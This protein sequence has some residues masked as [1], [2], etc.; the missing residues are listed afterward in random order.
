MEKLNFFKIDNIVCCSIKQE[1]DNRIY[2]SFSSRACRTINIFT[3]CLAYFGGDPTWDHFAQDPVLEY[4]RK[5][6]EEK[7]R[8]FDCP[9]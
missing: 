8:P 3:L 9:P 1:S 4:K 2:I 6:I 5:L 7:F